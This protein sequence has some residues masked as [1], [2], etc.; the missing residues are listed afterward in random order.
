M[1][2]YGGGNLGFTSDSK[3]V[4]DVMDGRSDGFWSRDGVTWHLTN[5]LEGGGTSVV[6]FYSSQVREAIPDTIRP[7]ISA[8]T[9]ALSLSLSLSLSRPPPPQ[10]WTVAKVDG[11]IKFLGVWGHT[12]QMFRSFRDDIFDAMFFVAGDMT[13]QGAATATAIDLDLLSVFCLG[14]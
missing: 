6:E 5:Y 13:G 4:I 3:A 9:R 7:P 12:V 1:W 11:A 2:I 8:L 10:E 14:P